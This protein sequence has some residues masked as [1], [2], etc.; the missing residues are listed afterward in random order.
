MTFHSA[1]YLPSLDLVSKSNFQPIRTCL[2]HTQIC[3]MTV[4][5]VS[6]SWTCIASHS[7]RGQEQLWV[8]VL[9][10]TF[11]GLRPH[12]CTRTRKQWIDLKAVPQ[13]KITA[14]QQR[15]EQKPQNELPHDKTNKMTCAPSKD[16][17]QPGHPPRLIWIFAVRMKKLWI[18]GYHWSAKRRLWSDW[19]DA[20]DDLS[21]HW[22]HKFC[23]F[24]HS[25]YL[26]IFLSLHSIFI[27]PAKCVCWGLL[28]PPANCVC[29]GGGILF[30]CPSIHLSVRLS[31]RNVLIFQYLEKAMPE[32]HRIWQT[33]WYPQDE[34]L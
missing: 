5:Y 29:G 6:F 8:Y 33:H 2:M 11:K 32:F 28:Y 9:N 3:G 34:H 18:L 15:E 4:G 25:L 14:R 13:S 21:F 19:A 12:T 23:W 1:M 30:S 31:I 24:F 16:S 7:G 17:D 27:P 20:Q 26:S 10:K 22:A